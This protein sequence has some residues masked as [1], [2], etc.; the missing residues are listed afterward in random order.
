MIRKFLKAI[1]VLQEKRIKH[2]FKR[3]RLNPYNPLSYITIIVCVLIGIVLF[4]FVGITKEMDFSE[5]P[6]KYQ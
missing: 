2:G 5:N 3:K 4:G 6:F 1:G